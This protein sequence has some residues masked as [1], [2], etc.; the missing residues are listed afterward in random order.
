MSKFIIYTSNPKG[1]VKDLQSLIQ[2]AKSANKFYMAE[3]SLNRT[4]SAVAPGDHIITE[5]GN[6]IYVLRV[7][8]LPIANMSAEDQEFYN[9]ANSFG[10]RP[11]NITKISQIVTYTTWCKTAKQLEAVINPN[12][13]NNKMNKNLSFRERLMAQFMPSQVDDVKVALDGTIVVAAKDG[14]YNGFNANGELVNYPDE[15]TLDTLPAYSIAKPAN[16]LS[17]GDIVTVNG[18][19][20]KVT[21]VKDGT[22]S[23]I[24][25]NGATA[26]VHP[27][28]D[29]I[30]GNSNVR[31]IVSLAG[32]LGGAGMNPMMLLALKDGKDSDSLL[33]MMLMSQQNGQLGL[34]LGNNPMMA[35]MLLG[36]KG[37]DMKDLFLMQA[38]SGAQTIFGNA[39]PAVDP[40]DAKIAELEAKLAA[41]EKN[42][43]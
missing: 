11:M 40:K 12:K 22:I 28:K 34:N 4:L 35:A 1:E 36:D 18:K 5:K 37:G 41:A 29:F 14:G 32:N 42:K 43:K 38:L 19:Y 31:V 33:P 7:L 9:M 20:I 8:E 13:V 10:L 30:F 3:I 24:N 6:H 21:A 27:I 26:C 25:F 39:A 2:F 23:G 17:K 15:M 16:Q